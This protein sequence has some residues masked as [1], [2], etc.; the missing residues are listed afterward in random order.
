MKFKWAIDGFF[1]PETEIE[2][3]KIARQIIEKYKS[4]YTDGQIM[5]CPWAAW[6]EIEEHLGLVLSSCKKAIKSAKK[7]IIIGQSFFDSTEKVIVQKSKSTEINKLVKV[8]FP[9]DK[10]CEIDYVFKENPA[11]EIIGTFVKSLIDCEVINL[12]ITANCK[13]I[14]WLV[15]FA[16]EE[17]IPI[18]FA[19]NLGRYESAKSAEKEMFA[20][21]HI[22]EN[23][24]AEQAGL[25]E[26]VERIEKAEDQAAEKI[27]PAVV[28][29]SRRRSFAQIG[30]SLSS[31]SRG[32][33]VAYL[34]GYWE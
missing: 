13:D 33:A 14:N 3:E 15:D 5:L 9:Q 4:E 28:E 27:I 19:L 16:I 17:N 1:M 34:S 8:N 31:L 7:V 18:I 11:F 6:Q 21:S 24:Y 29:L 32:K 22:L 20:I 2:Q 26:Q 12:A 23:A 30:R 10:I 25:A